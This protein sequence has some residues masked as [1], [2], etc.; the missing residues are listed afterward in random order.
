MK[1]INKKLRATY[2]APDIH[3]TG[4]HF[5]NELHG[6]LRNIRK[7]NKVKSEGV[8]LIVD[9]RPYNSKSKFNFTIKSKRKV[10]WLDKIK[11]FLLS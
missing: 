7:D 8:R 2:S 10:Y 11:K 5:T 4:V 6:H 9:Y 3:M 1:V